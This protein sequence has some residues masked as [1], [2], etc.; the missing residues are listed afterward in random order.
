MDNEKLE[1]LFK[2][3][4]GLLRMKASEYEHT[5]RR[6]GEIVSS[7]SLDDVCNEMDAFLTGLLN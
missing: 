1:E 3:W 6:N 4:N 5:A 7:P 2:R